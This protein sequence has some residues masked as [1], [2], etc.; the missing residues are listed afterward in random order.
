MKNN[1]IQEILKENVNNLKKYKNIVDTYNSLFKNQ[2]EI[3]KQYEIK[4]KKQ[5]KLINDLTKNNNILITYITRL[6]LIINKLS[7]KSNLN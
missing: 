2:Q 1:T 3:I 7:N 4:I 5:E 6:K